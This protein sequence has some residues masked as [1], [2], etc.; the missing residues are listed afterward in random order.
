MNPTDSMTGNPMKHIVGFSGGIDS[1]ACARWVLNRYQHEDVILLNSDAGGNE[2]PLT[3]TF[4]DWYSA[5]VHPVVQIKAIIADMDGRAPGKI[6]ELGLKHDDLLTFEL[7]A[8]LKQRFPS[9]RA[10]YC[11]HHLKLIPQRRWMDENLQGQEFIRYSGVRRDES[12]KRAGQPV[13]SWDETYSCKLICPLADWTKQMCFDYVKAHGEQINELY[14]LGFNRVG[15][16]PCINS[17]K[18]D[19]RGWAD[20]SPDMI[21]KVRGWEQRVGRTFFAPCVPPP[22]EYKH[23]LRAWRKKW[24]TV[25]FDKDGDEVEIV[26]HG[27]PDPPVAPYNWIDEVVEWSKTTHGGKQYG[28]H[29]LEERPACE[30]KY[31]LCE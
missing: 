28:L 19:I 26:R 20:R 18:E 2:H 3:Q 27:A 30:S 14:T 29:I 25:G 16:A 15:C 23:A 10:Q 6:A 24:T 12:A 8:I 31:G 17:G 7:L 22:P 9:R 5:N 21:D 4:I 13:E 1:Q 11:T